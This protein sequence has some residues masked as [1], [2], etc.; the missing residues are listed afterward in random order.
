MRK[1]GFSAEKYIE[2]QSKYI[3]ERI[4]KGEGRLYLEF[5]GKLVQDKHAMRVL[6]GFDEDAKIKLL[7]RMGD[8]AEII[9]CI[10]AGDIIKSKTRQDF[11]ITYDLEVLRLIDSFRNYNLEVNSVV[12]TRYEDSPSVNQFLAKLERRG[13]RTYKHMFTKGYPTDVDTI[14]S[15]EGYGANPYI[16]V[17]KPLVCVTGPG[18]GSGKLATSLSQ[19]YHE[20]KRGNKARYAKFETFPVWNLPLKHP[21]NIAYEAATADLK[22]VNLIDPFHLEAYGETSVN[23]NRDVDAFP[24]VRRIL[25]A[26]TGSDEGYKS[27][28]DMGVNRVGFGIIDDEA[29]RDAAVQEIIRRYLIAECSYRKGTI[30]EATLERCKL[31]ME[32]V[33]ATKYDRPAV[34]LAEQYAEVK[35]AENPERYENVVISAIEMPD[36]AIVTGRSSRRMVATAAMVLNALKYLAGIQDDMLIISPSIF[37]SMASTKA[38]I[39]HDKSSLNL[40][41]VIMAL[42]LTKVSNPFAELALKEIPNLKGCVAHCTAILSEKDEQSLKALGI[43]ITTNAEFSNNNLYSK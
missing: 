13:I 29:C 4:S 23:Y 16:E 34:A 18:G 25:H 8:Q 17:T 12:V 37:D 21:V 35:K 11:G 22:D 15:E 10:Y 43:D 26:I 9:I 6:P 41:E 40:E 7:Q 36:G 24:V 33:N 3:Q 2:E 30:D 28:T 31:L 42:T 19:V 14:V 27:P 39:F 32:E 5:G 38:G 20:Y 1:I